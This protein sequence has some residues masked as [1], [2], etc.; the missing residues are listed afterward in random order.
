MLKASNYKNIEPYFMFNF[1]TLQKVYA[2]KVENVQVF[3]E[4]EE[5]KSI[6]VK[7]CIENGIELEGIKKKVRFR[8]NLENFFRGAI[9]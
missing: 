1:R 9:K 3:I 7:W 5:R 8:Y 6:P 4:M 2:V